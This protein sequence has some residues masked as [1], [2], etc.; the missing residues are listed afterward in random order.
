MEW[1]EQ[2]SGRK[3]RRRRLGILLVLVLLGSGFILQRFLTAKPL[4]VEVAL[5]QRGTVESLVPSVSSG[6]VTPGK[7]VILSAEYPGTIR[8]ILVREGERVEAGATIARLDDREARNRVRSLEASLRAA[9]QQLEQARLALQMTA[10]LT[11]ATLAQEKAR[12]EEAERNFSRIK[13]LFARKLVSESAMDQARTE[14]AVARK[15]FESAL[16]SL[17]ERE[18]KAQ[19]VKVAEAKVEELTASL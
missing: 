4:A 17:R 19:A 11:D 6:T 7:E 5:V 15:R 13:S 9:Q 12:M 14:Y 3:G 1:E 2:K 10:S 8:Q 18:I 16:A